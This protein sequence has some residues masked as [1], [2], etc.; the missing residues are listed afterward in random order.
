MKT[1]HIDSVLVLTAQVITIMAV[2]ILMVLV[3]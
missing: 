3:W 2:C 1:E